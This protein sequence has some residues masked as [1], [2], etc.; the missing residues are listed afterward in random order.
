MKRNNHCRRRKRTDKKKN[1]LPFLPH[2]L[3]VQ[4]LLRLPVKSLIR[5][6]CVSTEFPTKIP[7]SPFALEEEEDEEGDKK[8]Y[9]FGY[10]HLTDDYLVVSISVHPLHFEF[11][12]LRANTWKEIEYAHLPFSPIVGRTQAGLLFND[13]I[14]WLAYHH[15]LRK[16]VIAVFDLI[17]STMNFS[18]NTVMIWTMKEYKV[19][20]SWTKTHAV[21]VDGT[22]NESFSPFCCTKNGDIIG[23]D[24]ET[25]LV[26][27]NDKGQLLEHRPYSSEFEAVVYTESL[28]SL[29]GESEQA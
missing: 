6:K 2:E 19:N 4:I 8:F 12:S 16:G 23:T 14:H 28:L 5:F 25:G 18:N 20:S 29:P 3:I 1:P 17:F 26:R 21:S 10:D 24:Q 7:F 15:D 22:P 9:G 13:G 27:Y 11:F